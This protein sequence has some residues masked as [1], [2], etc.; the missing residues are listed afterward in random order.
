MLQKARRIERKLFK[1]LLESRNYLHSEH[2][3]LKTAP[4]ATAKAAVSVSKKVSKSAVVRNRVRRRAYASLRAI[5]PSL[6]P[7]LY[8]LSAKPGSGKAS[9]EALDIELAGLLKKG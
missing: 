3:I 4:S 1:P 9:G 2:F 8:F 6:P 5:L 7:R